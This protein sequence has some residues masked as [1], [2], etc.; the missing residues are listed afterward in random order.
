FIPGRASA[1]IFST[2]PGRS[3]RPR[4]RSTP[5]IRSIGRALTP[6]PSSAEDLLELVSR[7]DLELIVAAV[8]GLLVGAPAQKRRGMAEARSLH[9]IVF[10]LAHPLDA[11]R[12]P[13]EILARAPPALTSG[14]ARH[15]RPVPLGPFAPRMA[16]ER[17]FAKRRELDRELLARRHGERRRDADM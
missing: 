16:V 11:Q 2:Y 9:V 10:D 8:A 14:H 4:K 7:R 5:T 1:S 6:S 15:V 13:R 3:G 12:L 17:V